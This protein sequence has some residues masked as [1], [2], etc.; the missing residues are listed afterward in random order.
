LRSARRETVIALAAALVAP[1][2]AVP[3]A[4][5]VD[6]ASASASPSGGSSALLEAAQHQFGAGDYPAAIATLQA[7]VSQDPLNAEAFYWLGRC[8]FET[9]DVDDAIFH[10]EKAVALQPQNSAYHQWLGRDYAAKADRDKSFFAARKVKKHFEQ[11]VALDPSNVS[12][13]RDLEE[14]CM[15]APWIVGG[16]KEEA[17]AQVDAIAKIDP[18]QGHLAR[19]GFDADALKRYDLAENEYRQILDAKTA[20][21]DPYFDTV[22]F[23][24]HRNRPADMNSVLAAVARVSPNDPRLHF[25]RAEAMI[26][27]GS[28]LDL[29]EQYIRSFLASTPDRSDWPS[30]PGAREWLGRLY[31]MQ[32]RLG[33]AAEQYRAS[34][35]LEPGRKSAQARLD[36]LKNSSR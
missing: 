8:Y 33:E 9:R 36:K 11:A 19:A 14:F 26:M 1:V 21:P 28:N 13:R 6:P 4:L 7:V 17:R 32:G 12:A 2:S 27:T 29:A 23:F 34:L 22:V 5:A 31:E 3:Q 16:N 35:Q 24:Q 20:D 18:I 25:Y 15:G 30:H 10:A